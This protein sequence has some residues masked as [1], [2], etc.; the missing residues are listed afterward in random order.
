MAFSIPTYLSHRGDIVQRAASPHDPSA[1]LAALYVRCKKHPS[2][3]TAVD[4]IH[5]TSHSS[6][7]DLIDEAFDRCDGCLSEKHTEKQWTESR[8]PEGAEL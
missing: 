3:W 6:V 4:L 8:F 7:F 1:N 2:V 5:A